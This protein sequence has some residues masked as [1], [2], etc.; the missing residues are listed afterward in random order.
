[1]KNLA[2]MAGF[3]TTDLIVAYFFGPPCMYLIES[4]AIFVVRDV[5]VRRRDAVTPTAKPAPRMAPRNWQAMNS[6]HLTT[7]VRRV[8]SIA[9][10]TTGLR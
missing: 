5:P 7:L 4:L 3:N 10:D 8:N 9:S 1:M 2:I 6:R